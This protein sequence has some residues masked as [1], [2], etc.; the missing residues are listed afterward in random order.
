MTTELKHLI[1]RNIFRDDGKLQPLTATHLALKNSVRDQIRQEEDL[2]GFF[3][4]FF[5]KQDNKFA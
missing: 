5:S 1:F 2:G 3:P 4:L